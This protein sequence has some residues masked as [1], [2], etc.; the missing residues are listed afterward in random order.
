[1]SNSQSNNRIAKNT[2][3]LYVRM[4]FVLVVSLYTSRVILTTLGVEDYGLYNVVAGFVSMF[5]FLNATLSSSMQ[6]FYNYEGTR[7]KEAGFQT[8]YETGFYIHVALSIVLLL[9]L[10]TF[11]LWYINNVMVLDASRLLAANVLFQSTVA[12]MIL[13]VM[14]IPYLGIIMAQEQ[15][16]FYAFVSIIDVVFKLLIVIALPYLPYDKL[17]SYSILLTGIS[18]LNFMLYYVYSKRKFH[19]ICLAGKFEKQLFRSIMSFSGWNLVGT[20]SFMLKGQGINMLLNAFFGTIVNAARG[21]AYQVNSA[22]TGFSANIATAFRPQI[23][24]SYAQQNYTRTRQMMFIESKICFVLMSLF[25]VPVALEI[26]YLLHLWLGDVVP[27]RTNLFA[28]LVLLD[29]L[30]CTLNTPCSQVVFASGNLKKYQIASSIVNLC[31][32]PACW[33]FLLAGYDATSV[34]VITVIFSILNQIVC[35]IYTNKVI[36]IGLFSYVKSVL[37][38]CTFAICFIPILPYAIHNLLPEG[39]LRLFIVGLADVIFG[40]AVT[41]FVILNKNERKYISNIILPKIRKS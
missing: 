33:V 27:E 11:G 32:I 19:Y 25:V 14:G 38:P 35:V 7:N 36:Q 5:G 12:S 26:D 34:F 24:N 28:I 30:V 10:E 1:M 39:L 13:V 4:I 8:V 16:D 20:F 17:V 37:M 18:V 31:L 2:L 15:M 21:I 6:R 3:F 22:I 9:V 41:F 40:L 29:S 23:V